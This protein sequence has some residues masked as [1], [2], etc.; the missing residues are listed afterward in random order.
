MYM[1]S[2]LLLSGLLWAHALLAHPRT[3]SDSLHVNQL[4]DEGQ[5]LCQHQRCEEAVERWYAHVRKWSFQEPRAYM[6]AD[7]YI[8]TVFSHQLRRY[9]GRA[10]GLYLEMLAVPAPASV[11]H[12]QKRYLAQLAPILPDSIEARPGRTLVTWWNQQ[13]PLPA[14]PVNERLV[15][16]LQRVRDAERLFPDSGS[17]AGFDERGFVYVRLGRPRTR[18]TLHIDTHRMVRALNRAG[19]VPAGS[20]A[21]LPN[22][23]W[24]YRHLGESVHYLFVLKGGRFRSGNFLD[25]IPSYLFTATRRGMSAAQ[26]RVVAGVLLEAMEGLTQELALRHPA[27]E[28][29]LTT[30]ERYR[31]ELQYTGGGLSPDWARTLQTQVRE[32]VREQVARRIAEEPRTYSS[33]GEG[34]P[35]LDTAL[36]IVR[37]LDDAGQTQVHLYWSHRPDLFQLRR[38]P[39][40]TEGEAFM[41]DMVVVPYTSTFFRG[42]EVHRQYMVQ[43]MREP[44]LQQLIIPLADT[45]R[46]MGIEWD[47]FGVQADTSG[48][49]EVTRYLATQT[50]TPRSVVPLQT[51]QLEMSD[52]LPVLKDTQQPYPFVTFTSDTPLGVYFEIYHLTPDTSGASSYEVTYTVRSDEAGEDQVAARYRV[53]VRDTR[54]QELVT[55]DLQPFRGKK[56]E[57]LL[58]IRVRDRVAGTEVQRSLPFQIAN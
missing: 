9:M 52:L 38:W 53:D 22:E 30:V 16:H 8:Q 47:L 15:E 55:L 13:D 12:I 27:Y 25:L 6:L 43:D 3:V 40:M 51:D 49:M 57:L 39:D 36:R 41:V 45:I 42:R 37:F 23:F 4:I 48:T 56:K 26:K 5:V 19:I 46:G 29:L 28:P 31:Q 35:L 33:V 24:E 34:N 18:A 44:V 7:A 50:L 32:V 11:Q 58:I 10:A 1:R 21:P 54:A 2:V 17:S 14:T 20:F